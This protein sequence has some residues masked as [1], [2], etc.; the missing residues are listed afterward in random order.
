MVLP[1]SS[2]GGSGSSS[3][4]PLLAKPQKKNMSALSMISLCRKVT[5]PPLHNVCMLSRPSLPAR[6]D[7]LQPP[8]ES[9][10]CN[11]PQPLTRL[12]SMVGSESDGVLP[13]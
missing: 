11:Q 8:P 5:C 4:T 1:A 12:I 2:A 6:L 13:L 7:C 3:S 9:A 10:V